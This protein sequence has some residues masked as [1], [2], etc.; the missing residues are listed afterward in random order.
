MQ[1]QSR[2]LLTKVCL[3]IAISSNKF[4]HIGSEYTLTEDHIVSCVSISDDFVA[5]LLDELFASNMPLNTQHM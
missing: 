2:H 5:P 1:E 4:E 3:F